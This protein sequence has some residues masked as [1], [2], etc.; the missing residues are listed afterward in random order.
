MCSCFN[1]YTGN[2]GLHSIAGLV[3]VTFGNHYVYFNKKIKWDI[4]KLESQKKGKND[5]SAILQSLHNK[6]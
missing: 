4:R 5:Q 3:H 2:Y 6:Y 1:S